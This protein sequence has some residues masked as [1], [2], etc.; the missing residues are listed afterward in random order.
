MKTHMCTIHG[1]IRL[2]E[3]NDDALDYRMDDLYDYGVNPENIVFDIDS[4][5]QLRRTLESA[6]NRNL[7]GKL[8]RSNESGAER[9][10][11]E[12]QDAVR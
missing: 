12:A 4:D 5:A 11:V 10:L 6:L 3:R 8:A 1:Y 7:A 2:P 9:S